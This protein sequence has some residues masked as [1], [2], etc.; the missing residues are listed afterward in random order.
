VRHRCLL[1]PPKLTTPLPPSVRVAPLWPLPQPN[2]I[3]M[4]HRHGPPLP[5]SM[6]AT[7]ASGRPQLSQGA[8]TSAPG[9]GGARAPAL[10]GG[11]HP[12][13]WNRLAPVSLP[14]YCKCM[15]VANVSYG[16]CKSRLR[17]CIYCCGYIRM[18]QSIRFRCS[19]VFQT[20]VT[21]VFIR[22]YIC[23]TYIFQVFL[24]RYYIRFAMAFQVF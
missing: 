13:G 1:P 12:D 11:S 20:Y 6:A 19:F 24:P 15:Y 2:A 7:C 9:T 8:P 21:S 18:L 23:F 3:G 5:L 14:L 22:C 10:A 17:C 16:C 4:S